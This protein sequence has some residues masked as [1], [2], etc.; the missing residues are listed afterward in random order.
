MR[1]VDRTIA[2]ETFVLR[3]IGLPASHLSR[4]ARM[5]NL[6]VSCSRAALSSKM[7]FL[8]AVLRI[9]VKLLRDFVWLPETDEFKIVVRAP[10]RSDVVRYRLTA[11]VGKAASEKSIVHP[12]G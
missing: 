1:P 10:F 8:T 11:F 9:I 3:S 2:C 5:R 7:R 6:L 4:A 12:T